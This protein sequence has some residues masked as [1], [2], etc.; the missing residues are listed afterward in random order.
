MVVGVQGSPLLTGGGVGGL[1]P[2]ARGDFLYRETSG[3][4]GP[5]DPESLFDV[6]RGDPLCPGGVRRPHIFGP[7]GFTRGFGGDSPHL[8]SG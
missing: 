6:A 4:L 8:E 2:T 7:P 3:G 1:P 5:S